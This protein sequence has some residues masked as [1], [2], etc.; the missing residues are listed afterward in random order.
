MLIKMLANAD[1][2][3]GGTPTALF[4]GQQYDVPDEQAKKLISTGSAKAV[5]GPPSSEV[6][7]SGKAIH[8]PPEDKAI[9]A[10][11]RRRKKTP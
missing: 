6:P 2:L 5:D 7:A 1:A 9:K 8:G 10:P 4:P 11:V 3:I